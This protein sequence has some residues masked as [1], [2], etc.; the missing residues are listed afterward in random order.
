[1]ESEVYKMMLWAV[2]SGFPKMSVAQSTIRK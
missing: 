1:M 2:M